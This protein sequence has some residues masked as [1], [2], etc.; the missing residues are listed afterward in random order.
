MARTR[1]LVCGGR[2]YKGRDR[3][4]EWLDVIHE[5]SN[6]AVVIHGACCDKEGNLRGADRWAEEWAI[7]REV[8]YYGVPAKWASEGR[9][10]G[11]KRNQWMLDHAKPEIVLACPGGSGT[12][13]MR[14]I[15]EA[16]GI[17]VE[18]IPEEEK[19]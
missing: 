3:V 6:I 1:V 18:D 9:S 19:E 7:S 5:D 15:A 17:W 2:D 10:A 13:H 14:R 12:A 11:P 16:V 8:P 4:F